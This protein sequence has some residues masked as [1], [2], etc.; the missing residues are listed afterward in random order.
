MLKKYNIEEIFVGL[1]MFSLPLSLK[2][3]NVCLIIISCYFIYKSFKFG[4]VK[5]LKFH[6]ISYIFFLFQVIS[7]F[8]ST[9]KD[10]ALNKVIL[11][12][13]FVLFPFIFT[14]FYEKKISVIRIF[15]F[16]LIGIVLTILYAAIGFTYEIIFL[17][18]RYDYG[19][20]LDLFTKY[21]PHHIYLSIYILIAIYFVFIKYLKFGSKEIYVLPLFF[22]LIFFLS[23]RIAIIIAV[24]ILPIVFFY[25]INKKLNKKNI[26]LFFSTILIFILTVVFFNDF[27]RDKIYY[28][29]H[30]LFNI[31]NQKQLTGV[32][33]RKLVWLTSIDLIKQSLFL[34]YGVGDIASVLNNSYLQNNFDKLIGLNC[35]NQY[36]QWLMNHG[37]FLTLV[38]WSFIINI[39]IKLKKMSNYLLL[40]CWFIVLSFFLTESVLERQ[41]GVVIFAFILNNSLFELHRKELKEKKY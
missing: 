33:N 25:K 20:A 15:N 41:W 34:G 5:Y 26:I 30:D 4:Y 29:Y 16:F 17:N 18:T 11:Y 21:T 2:F 39:L 32:S 14:S 23:S 6:I 19:R 24:L 7:F 31:H 1:I 13:S 40:F 9:N 10:E 8:L 22:A 38:L 36:F 27:V 12:S 37:L 28:T 35:H 3:N